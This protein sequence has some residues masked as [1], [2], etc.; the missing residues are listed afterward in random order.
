MKRIIILIL[1]STISNL[2][3]NQ[4]ALPDL[5]SGTWKYQTGNEVFAVN[6][7]KTPK[8]Y[9]GHY[10][11]II[12]DSN[13]NQINIIYNSDKE[14]DHSGFNWPYAIFAG[15][16][17]Q[18]YE[19][20]AIVIDNTVTHTPRGNGFID[21]YLYMKILNHMCG[22]PGSNCALQVEWKVSKKP[23]LQDQYEPPFNIPTDI[24]LTKQ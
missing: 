23:G 10:K 1:I 21:G 17:S 22:S 3:Y 7:W 18:N 19:C 12:V 8:G 16:V 15:N 11:K 13:G 20:G 4:T 2:A 5:L 9:E 24:I 14:I 6:F